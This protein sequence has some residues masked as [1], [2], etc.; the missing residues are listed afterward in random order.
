MKDRKIKTID[1]FLIVSGALLLI[2][3]FLPLELSG[4]AWIALVPLFFALKDKSPLSAFLLSYLYGILFFLGTI[5]W[6]VYV[7]LLG[8]ILLVLYLALYFG[9]FGLVARELDRQLSA[10][11]ILTVSLSWIVLEYLR[12]N[13]FTGLGWVLLGYSQYRNLWLIQIADLGGVYL[14]SFLVIVINIAA[15][16]ILGGQRRQLLL[17]LLF[18]LLSLGYGYFK[19]HSLE[20]REGVS[21]LRVSVVQGN[22]PQQLKW[23][24]RAKDYIIDNYFALTRQVLMDRPDLIVWPE[25]SLP[26]VL[27]E[28]L[29]GF[30]KVIDFAR[31]VNR[32]LLLGAVRERQGLY[33]NSAVLITANTT[34]AQVYD[35]LHLVPFGEYIPLK[36]ILSFL[37]TVVPIGDFTAGS[38]YTVFKLG[39]SLPQETVNFST[40]ICFEDIFPQIARRFVKEGAGLLINITNDAWFKES[41]CPFQHLQASVFRAVENRTFLIRAA[42]TGVSGF[43]DPRGKIIG[44][45]RDQ[46]AKEIFV[47]GHLTREVKI[48]G[49]SSPYNKYGDFLVLLAVLLLGYGIIFRNHLVHRLFKKG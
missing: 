35:K 14:V 20:R 22:I 24:S 31:E 9:I 28:N 3:S 19:I 7:T 29:S 30:Q 13:L 16:L 12:S 37:E 17:P 45:V 40:L 11:K 27:E 1:I 6:L 26:F 10:F 5:Y 46:Q 23:D 15:Y 44:R 21:S 39:L 38:D 41:S 43:I 36:D 2:L 32:P 34:P 8:F 49:I 48:Y 42:N 25:A 33:F 18:I 47:P 4:L